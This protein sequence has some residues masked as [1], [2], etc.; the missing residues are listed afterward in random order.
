[1]R[2][3][4]PRHRSGSLPRDGE[5][6][7][8][9]DP[10]RRPPVLT[11]SDTRA[12]G[13]ARDGAT[14][15]DADFRRLLS[16]VVLAALVVRVVY[17]IVYDQ[18][19]AAPGGDAFYYHW[20]ANAIAE[21]LGFVEPYGW[22]C[23][24]LIDPSAAHPP[25][26]S[27]Y[28]ALFS[29]LG[30]TSTLVHRLATVLAGSA[31]VLL[32]GLAGREWRDARTGV[33]AAA[34]AAVAPFLW[35]NDA[36]LMSETIFGTTIALVV[37]ASLRYRR[38]PSTKRAGW[39][40]FSVALAT[41]ARAEAIL[42]VPLLV[43]PLLVISFRQR[44][45]VPDVSARP[46]LRHAGA[47]ALCLL[48]ALAPWTAYNLRRFERP[49]VVSTGLGSVLAV[50]NCDETYSGRNLGVWWF[51]CGREVDHEH[52]GRDPGVQP[53][54][55]GTVGSVSCT[56]YPDGLDA[57]L[58]DES[59]R[60]LIRRR[61]GVTYIREHTSDLV[62]VVPARVGRTFEVFRPAE[63]IVYADFVEHRGEWTARAAQWS[64]FL[65]SVAGIA[66]FFRARR[67]RLPLLEI[68]AMFALVV[69]TSIVTY[70]N[71]RFRLPFDVVLTMLA[72]LGATS[73]YERR[74]Q[75]P[76]P[77]AAS[78]TRTEGPVDA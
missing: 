67:E 13:G 16:F 53:V 59:E 62:R 35:I 74:R 38:A 12:G 75:R 34:I 70:G 64:F 32:V 27:A 3:R 33:V 65:L 24:G 15:S 20:Q 66:G 61:A 73:W 46:W 19:H 40:G 45:P 42:L 52:I 9:D 28:L 4:R 58:G 51:P 47:A 55:T 68:V 43:L 57:L 5:R 69:V 60:E 22:K 71:V 78:V 29:V 72:A 17:A 39:L 44:R 37:L 77:D 26:Y 36:L 56:S 18:S 1:M 63:S 7:A 6:I 8:G 21:G 11:S 10:P 76:A 41:L 54:E 2:A 49:V 50:A 14:R 23:S 48:A 31:T 30:G 25:L